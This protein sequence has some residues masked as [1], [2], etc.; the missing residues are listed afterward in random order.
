LSLINL[1]HAIFM[2]GFSMTS[3][4]LLCPSVWAEPPE[5]SIQEALEKANSY[6]PD[7][8]AASERENQAESRVGISKSGYLP[9]INLEAIDSTGFPGSTAALG[10][11]GLPGSPF[12]SGFSGGAVL[13]QNIVD[14]GRTYYSVKAAES[15][16]KSQKISTEINRYQ[17]EQTLIQAF[18]DCAL[19]RS[20]EEAWKELALDTDLVSHEVDRFV[21]TGQR[22]IVDRYLAR[23]QKE[24]AT[25][26]VSDF[27]KRQQLATSRVAL[28][29][30]ISTAFVCPSFSADL[31]LL[32]IKLSSKGTNPYLEFAETR[33]NAAEN[34]LK[35]AQSENLPKVIGIASAG[36]LQNTHIVESQSY[37]LGV[38][39]V[40]PLFQGFRIKNEVDEAAS[41]VQEQDFL[42][43]SSRLQIEN[44]NTLYDEKIQS[45]N[46]RIQNLGIELENAT[47]A[48]EVA[49]KRYLGF[50]GTLV[51]VR[52]AL[53]NLARVKSELNQ[54]KSIFYESQ[55]LKTALNSQN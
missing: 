19:N 44:V 26:N 13:T 12:R 45:A 34:R 17:T 10:V 55:F 37:S 7:L 35:K 28:L 43:D 22:S 21:N 11:A 5:L 16:L 54:A 33:V 3:F 40:F 49:K 15:D 38:G 41:I 46:V 36:Y 1:R 42:V 25:T 30:G 32:N 48:F 47:T 23:A 24:Q 14:F 8:K 20:Q 9:D 31:S 39:I 4:F 52:D 27:S 53:T 51:D 6:S 50:Q 18:V 2:A 29:T